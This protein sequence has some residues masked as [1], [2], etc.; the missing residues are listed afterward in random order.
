MQESKKKPGDRHGLKIMG[1]ETGK[2]GTP[3]SVYN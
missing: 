3:E 1:E 2:H